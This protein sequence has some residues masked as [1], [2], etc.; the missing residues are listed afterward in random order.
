MKLS[1]WHKSIGDEVDWYNGTHCDKVY[2]SK[3]FNFSPEYEGEI[4]ADEIVRGGL[5]M[6]FLPLVA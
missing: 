6:P 5:D 4:D 1:A 2:V 3:V